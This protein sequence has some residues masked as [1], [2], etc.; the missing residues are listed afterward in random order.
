[1]KCSRRQALLRTL[2]SIG[3]A[4]CLTACLA[5]TASR[6][7]SPAP[8]YYGDHPVARVY[9]YHFIDMRPEHIPEAFK[10]GVTRHLSQALDQSAIPHDQL[11][12]GDTAQGEILRS[13]MKSR[14]HY[15]ATSVPVGATIRDNAE[16]D[17]ALA[18]THRLIAFPHETLRQGDG[19]VLNV[20]WDLIDAQTGNLEWSVYTQT[21]NLRGSMPAEDAEAMAKGY[22][23]AIIDELRLRK[24]I[25]A[26]GAPKT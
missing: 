7:M 21:P 18:P 11:W 17:I 13:D 25:P 23:A 14:T 9:V 20:K 2:F 16:R 26:A 1:M 24:V 10:L 22:A 6:V 12:F 8:I 5:T 19:V 15:N 3:V 4:S